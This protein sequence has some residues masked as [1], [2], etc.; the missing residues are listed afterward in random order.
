MTSRVGGQAPNTMRS[1]V[2]SLRVI[3][4]VASL[5]LALVACAE[6]AAETT[7]TSTTAPTTTT[8]TL[9]P[10]PAVDGPVFRVGLTSTLS[11]VNWWEILGT[12]STPENLALVSHTKASL[13]TLTRPGFVTVPDMAAANP[14]RA[15]DTGGVW[16]VEQPIRDDVF[17]SDGVPVTAH[18]LAFYFDVTRE[19]GLGAGHA[20]NFPASVVDVSAPDDFIVRIEFASPPSIVDWQAGVGLAPFVPAHFWESHVEEARSRGT[21]VAHLY[22]VDPVGEPSAGPLVFESW[23]PGEMAVTVSNPTYH[24]RGTETTLYS[25]G[26]ARV[27]WPDGEDAVYGGGASGSVEAHHVV[28]PFVSGV[29]WIE[30]G[31]PGPAYE[32]LE[33]GSVDFVFDPEGM[34]LAMRNRLV[35]AGDLRISTSEAEGFRFLG[36][37]LRKP[38]MS[39]RIFREAVAT[40]IDKELVASTH[41]GGALAPAYTVVHPGLTPFYE[42]AVR[43]PGW[44]ADAPMDERERFE[45][46]VA[47][48]T[49]A[50]YTWQVSPELVF[51]D[52]GTLVDVVAG[53][54]LRMPNGMAVPELTILVAPASGDD[55]MRAT[56]ALWIAHWMGHLG[57]DVV[58][59][60]TDLGSMMSTAVAPESAAAALAWDLKVSGW[61]R[62]QPGLP[63]LTLV[64]LFH[65]R[66]GVE[67]GG[68]N[69]T[70][71]LSSEFDAAAD[72]F[73]AAITISEAARWTREMERIVAEDLPYVVLYRTSV[74]EAFSPVVRFPVEG[75]MGGH[76]ATG[77]AWPESVR[78]VRR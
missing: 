36:F 29:H 71:Y 42:P 39:D 20:V 21:G 1:T 22:A 60:T 41:L 6:Q 12:D 54:G 63:G 74:T 33:G 77:R 9:P 3:S 48:L 62:A 72:S 2:Y 53:S 4:I 17:W 44:S 25:D 51:D 43:R 16:V 68:L 13:F 52:A 46:A 66:G 23:K 76:A 37:N 69:T 55:P 19:F 8:T 28:G 58:V 7:T 49:E 56:F 10:D 11:S 61:G 14:A 73:S 32:A 75:V 78:L 15:R 27:A 18:D 5:A 38:P 24:G 30:Y 35:A 67:V 34:S 64:A 31:S 40:L 65:S 47:I 57:I 59:D 45:T 50:G 70:G 26:S